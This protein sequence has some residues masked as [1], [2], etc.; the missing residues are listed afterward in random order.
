MEDSAAESAGIRI[1][2]VIVGVNGNPI[3]TPNELRNGVGILRP[4]SEVTLDIVRDSGPVT[5]TAV[6]GARPDD[7]QPV[8]QEEARPPDPIF[9]GVELAEYRRNGVAALAVTA[10]D[11]NSLAAAR[12]LQEGDLII[13]I[14]RQRVST[15]AEARV[16]VASSQFIQLQIRR[17]N[18]DRLLRLR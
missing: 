9:E 16:L 5:I 18:R 10:V 1:N 11:P 7:G 13:A 4:G 6:L 14:N 12:G 17:G 3:T 8:T 2:D 15:L